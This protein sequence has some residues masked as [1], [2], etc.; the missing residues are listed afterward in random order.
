MQNVTHARNDVLARI[1]ALL[2]SLQESTELLGRRPADWPMV[3]DLESIEK[4]LEHGCVRW[5]ETLK[6]ERGIK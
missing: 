6:K 5:M 1:Q 3:G 2:A 4:V